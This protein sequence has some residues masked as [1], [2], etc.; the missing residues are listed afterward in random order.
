MQ[1]ISKFTY[2]GSGGQLTKWQPSKYLLGREMIILASKLP[3]LG[4][5]YFLKWTYFKISLTLHQ[6]Q[7]ILSICRDI[8]H[9]TSKTADYAILV[10]TCTN[11][12]FP[13]E[14]LNKYLSA[15]NHQWIKRPEFWSAL[16]CNAKWPLKVT[17]CQSMTELPNKGSWCF[18]FTQNVHDLKWKIIHEFLYKGSIQ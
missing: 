17:K 14:M 2:G 16:D 6:F 8:F 3:V 7:Q 9:K 1:N 5:C 11:I 4:G 10:S 13:N 12:I 15:I 18:K